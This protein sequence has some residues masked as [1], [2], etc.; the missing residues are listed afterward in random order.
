MKKTTKQILKSMFAILLVFAMT[1]TILPAQETQ[2]ASKWKKSVSKTFTFKPGEQYLCASMV[3]QLKKDCTI[4][5]QPSDW[6]ATI[7]VCEGTSYTSGRPIKDTSHKYDTDK[8]TYSATYTLKKGTYCIY[9]LDLAS[10]STKDKLKFTVKT[11]KA[12]LKAGKGTL[13][14]LPSDLMDDVG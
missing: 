14:L 2:A 7:Q 9:S 11:S 12:N 8:Q 1:V 10:A 4:T 6:T 13:E 3:I 5:V